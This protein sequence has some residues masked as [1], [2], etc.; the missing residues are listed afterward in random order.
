[1]NGGSFSGLEQYF[2]GEALE[3]GSLEEEFQDVQEGIYD[4]K[5]GY[6]T[7]SVE[8][9]DLQ[10]ESAP[11]DTYYDSRPGDVILNLRGTVAVT[12]GSGSGLPREAE[13]RRNGRNPY[14]SGWR[15]VSGKICNPQFQE[16][17]H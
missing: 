14:A 4:S 17:I 13:E 2:A 6:G 12:S 9:S 7:I 8:I 15:T 5:D 1:M 3:Q 11:A 16:L 10:A